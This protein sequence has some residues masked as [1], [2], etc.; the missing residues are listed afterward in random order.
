MEH[1]RSNLRVLLRVVCKIPFNQKS[2]NL[3]IKLKLVLQRKTLIVFTLGFQQK[4][5]LKNMMKLEEVQK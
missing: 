1:Q 5:Q 3:K 2:F 4:N